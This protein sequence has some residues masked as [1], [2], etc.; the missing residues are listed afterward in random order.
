MFGT[1]NGMDEAMYR[2]H[3]R[4]LETG[5]E[6]FPYWGYPEQGRWMIYGLGLPDSVLEKIYHGN[7]ERL[8]AKFKGA[9]LA[10]Y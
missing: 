5:D 9:Q 4:W 2:N 1:D 6:Y 7:A 3:F 8:F 10:K